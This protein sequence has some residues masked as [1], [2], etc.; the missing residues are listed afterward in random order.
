[1]A[2]RRGNRNW[3]RGIPLEVPP[4]MPTEFEAVVQVLHLEEQSYVKSQQLRLW[5]EL[6][7]SRCYVP[8]WCLIAG[9]CRSVR[10]SGNVWEPEMRCSRGEWELPGP[11]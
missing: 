10:I 4:A 9:K 1:M 3:L 7:R 11:E 2:Y 5:C 6:N 8:E